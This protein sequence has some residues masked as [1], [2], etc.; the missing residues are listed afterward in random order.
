MADVLTQWNKTTFGNI[1]ARKRILMARLGSIQKAMAVSWHIG[2]VR[3]NR[4]L[5]TQLDEVLNQEE[6]LW[7]ERSRE[8]W[9]QS[10]D[11]N[12]KIYHLSTN[13]RQKQKRGFI[14]K[15][16]TGREAGDFKESGKLLHNY[17]TNIFVP[18][19][20]WRQVTSR[21][22]VPQQREACLEQA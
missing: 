16:T 13:V 22:R 11:R 15:D 1:H 12:T 2:L 14:L 21:W 10:S 8:T 9:I 18:G 7:Y 17:F 20:R 5:C 4:K 6:L 3:L 19:C